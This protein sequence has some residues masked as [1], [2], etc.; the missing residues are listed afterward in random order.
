MT[1]EG[2]RLRDA[3]EK[4][5]LPPDVPSKPVHGWTPLTLISDSRF[6]LVW[7]KSVELS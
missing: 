4:V 7:M 1:V 6:T 5:K 2:E 3:L